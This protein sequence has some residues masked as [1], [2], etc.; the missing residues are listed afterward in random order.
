M[1]YCLQNI[2]GS[3]QYLARQGIALRGHETKDGNLFQLL[4]FKARD[5]VR[6]STWLALCHDYTSP[7]VQNEVLQMLGN[8][9]VRSIAQSIQM[10]P[11]LQYS[12]II[13]GTQ[14]VTGTEQEAICFRYV[15]HDLVPREVF[16][17]LYEVPGT[18]GVE[19]ARMAEDVLLRLNIP[20]SGLRGQTYDGAANMSGKYSGAQAELKRQQPLALYVHC[21]AHCLNLI[22]QSACR[23]SPLINDSLQWVHELGTLNKQ[24]GKFKNIF[25]KATS[26][27]VPLKSLRPLCPTRWTVR[28]KAIKAVLS[29][30]E[31]VLSSLEEMASSGSNTGMRANGLRERFEKGKTVLGLCLA[32]EVIEELECLNTSL[33]KRTETVAG[34]RSAIQCVK[35]T[36][37]AKRNEEN[38]HEVF[39]KAVAMVDSLGIEPIQIPH[40]RK[41]PK[42]FT[43]EA[44]QHIPKS[45]E[46]H[47]RTE[48]SK[49][50]DSVHIQFE[51]RFNQPDLNVLQN[52]EETLLTG[53][54]ND[55]VDQYPELNR[56]ILKVQLAMFRSKYTVK[57][58]VEVAEIM[59]GLTVEVRGLFD[60]VESLIRLLL[61]IPVASAEAERS[62]S[63]LRRLKTWLRTTMTQVRLNNL[64][65]CHVHQET[66]DNIDLKEIYQQF[67]S[68]TE[69]R[70]HVFGSFK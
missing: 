26:S 12:L 2:V 48:F 14:D 67:I 45:A 23:A 61:V 21:G 66:L 44:S 28:G 27:E 25:S 8:C 11:V 50:L 37:H 42:R 5:D 70:R 16:I 69:R 17:G 6:L 63:A 36:V 62:F 54:V 68:V 7:Q 15:D 40:Q 24:S 29:Q 20:I 57:S 32:L 38:F 18:T 19:I 56:D 41:P 43:S 1:L 30:Y 51:E 53:E 60:Q 59:R 47:Y 34:M 39:E 58:S 31:R 9:I 46:E 52:L 64:A 22:T 13:D 4:K 33:Q 55:I 65:V 49:M 35:S 10:L 3:I